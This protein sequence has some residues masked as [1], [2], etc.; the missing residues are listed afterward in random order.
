MMPVE[1]EAPALEMSPFQSRVLAV[2]ED[3]D[4]FLGGGRGGGKSW[5]I[6]WLILRAVEQYGARVRVLY[7]RR[8]YA[9]VRDFEA[10]LREIFA[11]AYG[12]MARYNAA[13][14]CWRLP[15]GAHVELGQLESETDYLKYQGRS[16][17]LICIDEAGHYEDPGLLDRLRSNLRAPK[18]LTT[19]MVL[20][21]NPGDPG[22]HWLTRRFV[23]RAEPWRPFHEPAS[24]RDFVYAPSTA[25]DNPHIDQDEYVRQLK[26]ACASDPELLRAW[27]TGDWAVARGAYFSTVV[28]EDRN[29]FGPWTPA[30]LAALEAER[31]AAAPSKRFYRDVTLVSPRA[32]ANEDDQFRLFLAH[33]FGSAAPSVTYVV[34]VSPGAVGPDGCWYPR[35]SILLLDELATN[36]P[37]SFT[38]GLGWTVPKLAEAIRELADRWGM[39]PEGCADDAIFARHGHGAGSVSEE[40]EAEGVFFDPARKA[41]R[42]TGWQRMRR[43]LEAAGTFDTP[44]LYVSRAC[45]YWWATVPVLPRD[46]R[47]VDDLDSRGADHAADATRYAITYELNALVVEDILCGPPSL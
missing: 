3:V 29:A 21:A 26:A 36:E 43:L 19:R 15:N 14:H 22:H 23:F 45:E 18:G 6:G 9:S 44:G 47:R 12:A 2:S 46:P 13:D 5:A 35:D 28:A 17:T 32:L 27:L 1:V 20:A 16:F 41:D 11:A 4:L 10:V 7:L 39:K 40:F 24:G 37:G 30:A 25:V 8:T 42:L 38:R 34:A 33:D 31:R